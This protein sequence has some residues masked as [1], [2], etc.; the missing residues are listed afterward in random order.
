[1]A[2]NKPKGFDA[3]W[4]LPT[5]PLLQWHST[6]HC[7]PALVTLPVTVLPQPQFGFHT[8][9]LTQ[10]TGLQCLLESSAGALL[11]PKGPPSSPPQTPESSLTP[12]ME[13]LRDQSPMLSSW[14]D[15]E[16][17]FRVQGLI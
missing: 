1:M 12:P 17:A 3:L 9:R 11:Q 14:F 7:L 13:E 10:H 8:Q 6:L 16:L 2:L 15:K 5:G 4:A